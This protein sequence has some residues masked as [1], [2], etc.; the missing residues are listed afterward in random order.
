MDQ[1]PH[2]LSESAMMK[3][4]FPTSTREPGRRGNQGETRAR[5]I[6][7]TIELVRQEGVSA[8]TTS[9]ITRAAGIAQPGF[10]AHFKNVDEIVRHAVSRVVEDIRKETRVARRRAFERYRQPNA[11]LLDA[12][13]A[14]YRETIEVFLSDPTYAELLLRYRRDPSVLGGSMMGVMQGIRDEF[15]ADMWASAEQSGF[16]ERHRPLVALW[17]EQLLALYFAGAESLLDG[18]QADREV[19]YDSLARSSYAIMRSMVRAADLSEADT[20]RRARAQK[21][22]S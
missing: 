21:R 2:A 9:R 6:Q 16:E 20:A 4:R 22:S 15:A 10:Y 1:T 13:R 14:A 18:R 19:V 11:N 17:S 7:V 5:L 3:S 8:L 12:F